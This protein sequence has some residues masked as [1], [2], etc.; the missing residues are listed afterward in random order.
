MDYSLFRR[1]LTG[2]SEYLVGF[3]TPNWGR[4]LDSQPDNPGALVALLVVSIEDGF[5]TD[6]CRGK[7]EAV[8]E[9]LGAYD[10]VVSGWLGTI[11]RISS[12]ASGVAKPVAEKVLSWV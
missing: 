6:T 5:P 8:L 11:D 9:V 2:M 7:D 4:E 3:R 12:S 10:T 1:K